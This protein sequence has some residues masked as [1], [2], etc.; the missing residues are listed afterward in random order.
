MGFFYRRNIQIIFFLSYFFLGNYCW[1]NI[2]FSSD[3]QK[4]CLTNLTGPGVHQQGILWSPDGTKYAFFEV[5]QGVYQMNLCNINETEP[6]LIDIFKRQMTDGRGGFSGQPSQQPPRIISFSWAPDSKHFAIVRRDHKSGI[7]IGEIGKEIDPVKDPDFTDEKVVRISWFNIK[8]DDKSAIVYVS[9]KEIKAVEFNREYKPKKS[10]VVIY[11]AESEVY[12][13]TL[14]PDGKMMVW[15]EYSSSRGY[16]RLSKCD[17]SKDNLKC[18]DNTREYLTTSDL[19]HVAPSFAPDGRYIAYYSSDVKPKDTGGEKIM[20]LFVLRLKDKDNVLATHHQ[21]RTLVDYGLKPCW[22][23]NDKIVYVALESEK[24]YPIYMIQIS[25]ESEKDMVINKPELLKPFNNPKNYKG[26]KTNTTILDVAVSPQ[27]D[28]IA[29]SHN[30]I[31]DKKF[32]I[33]FIKT[34]DLKRKVAGTLIPAP[35]IV[36]DNGKITQDISNLK[37]NIKEEGAMSPSKNKVEST[38]E[39][40]VSENSMK[41]PSEIPI[42]IAAVLDNIECDK[43]LVDIEEEFLIAKMVQPKFF[44]YYKFTESNDFNFSTKKID[45]IKFKKDSEKEIWV[46]STTSDKN[47]FRIA[48]INDDEYDLVLDPQVSIDQEL[49]VEKGSIELEGNLQK[50]QIM[51]RILEISKFDETFSFHLLSK[52]SIIRTCPPHIKRMPLKFEAIVL[53]KES[54]EK[55]FSIIPLPLPENKRK[56]KKYFSENSDVWRITIPN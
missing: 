36:K 18:S 8:K 55:K 35:I 52:L 40:S 9:G 34:V 5:G 12:Y 24:A 27:S 29:F 16:L 33:A 50:Y 23:G 6:K 37:T 32:E 31:E 17:M 46:F 13:P 49:K 14:S 15:S 19:H 47:Q 7:F 22:W 38:F 1:G 4:G 45:F 11:R 2:E 30:N 26:L 20:Q 44:S 3:A 10:P 39:K 53:F 41:L 43:G 54:S 51:R 28:A 56:Y 42:H 21:V 25:G 48:K